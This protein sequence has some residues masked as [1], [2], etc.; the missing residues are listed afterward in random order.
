MM[1]N[2]DCTIYEDKTLA[3]HT[4]KGVYWKDSRGKTVTAKGSLVTDNVLVFLYNA[5]YVPKAGDI[6]IKG[7]AAESYDGST[8]QAQSQSMKALRAAHPDFA[9]IKSVDDCRYG[10]LKHIEVIAR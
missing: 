1:I 7:I 9:V 2:A 4:Y 5:D 3:R 8:Q 6:L 10:G